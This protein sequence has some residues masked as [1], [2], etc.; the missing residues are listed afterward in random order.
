M[1][2]AIVRTSSSALGTCIDKVP[3]SLPIVQL[4]GMHT[5][6]WCAFGALLVRPKSG[7]IVYEAVHNGMFG[8]GHSAGW[9][10]DRQKRA[11][12]GWGPANGSKSARQPC[13]YGLSADDGVPTLASPTAEIAGFQDIFRAVKT[14]AVLVRFWCARNFSAEISGMRIGRRASTISGS[15]ANELTFSPPHCA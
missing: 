6:T 12:E 5:K 2:P 10:P 14:G 8:P 9:S 15:R 1:R 4:P 3:A 7:L 11:A 13:D